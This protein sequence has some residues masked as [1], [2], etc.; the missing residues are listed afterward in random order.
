MNNVVGV[1]LAG[2]LARRMGGGD[3]GL[4]VLGGRPMMDR[5]IERVRRQV[6]VLILNANGDPER[7]A[8]YGLDVVPDVI[9]GFAGPLAGVLTGLEWAAANAPDAQW[10]ATFTVDAPFVPVDLVE[11]L[12]AAVAANGADLACAKSAGRAHPV[13]GLW[14]VRLGGDLRRA[15]IDEDMR[16]IDLWT[17]RYHLI[18]VD[19]STDPFDPFF[20][21]NAPEHLAEAER[22]LEPKKRGAA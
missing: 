9:E 16:K 22:L 18:E 8:G 3:K 17:A 20:N 4:S 1:L 14:P 13:F 10:V 2:G 5:I 12:D 19:F 6:S 15:M 21:V 7:F 11:R